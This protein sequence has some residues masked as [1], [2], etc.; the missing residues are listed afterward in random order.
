[1]KQQVIGLFGGS[2][3]VGQNL[4]FFLAKQGYAI[5]VFTRRRK[6]TRHLWMNSSI[7][8]IEI[9]LENQKHLTEAL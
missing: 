8:I 2:G 6:D 1:M 3:F 5:R 4:A 7:E 9:D